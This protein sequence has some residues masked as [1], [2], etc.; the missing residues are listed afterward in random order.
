M[1]AAAF[2][3]F[4]L[5]GQV[6]VDELALA[7]YREGSLEVRYV[8]A[9]AA[10]IEQVAAGI[11][12]ARGRL[13]TRRASEIAGALG[14]VGAR[15]VDPTDPMRSEALELLPVTSG[16][17]PK[18]ASA[19]LDGMAADWTE[20]PLLRLLT[21]ELGGARAL[22]GFVAG[23]PD[24]ASLPGDREPASDLR[25]GTMAVG[26][27][28]CVQIVAG[29]VPGVGVTALIRSLL[30]KGPTLLKPG[31]GDVVLPVL[32]AR[33]LR[34]ADPELADALA[35]V[36][37]P[38]G[39]G[40]LEEAALA[41]ADVVT[42]YGSD[43]TVRALRARTPVTA[44]FVSYHHRVSV[45]VVGRDALASPATL[46]RTAAEVAEAVAFFDQRGC[47]CPQTIFVE[48]PEDLASTFAA[49]VADELDRLEEEL[50]SGALDAAE[51]SSLHQFRGAVEMMAAAGDLEVRHGG[52]SP[53]TV[54]LESGE[55][56]VGACPGRTVRLRVVGD[57]LEVPGLLTPI[58]LHLQTVGVAGGVDAVEA[59]AAELGMLGACRVVPF[60]AVPFPPPW[61]HH[62]GRGPLRDLVRWV[63][64]ERE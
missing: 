24:G 28:L 13:S 16:L 27:R 41:A 50:P 45:G 32:F 52:A 47:V 40:E 17:S 62:D 51:A 8:D 14:R 18:M 33:A 35:V 20:A 49:A 38:G 55:R 57:V 63:D 46:E 61:W 58:S 39:R 59:L 36:Y 30:L 21:A 48:G 9:S 10:W 34:E 23:T 26:P 2:D 64:L 6:T 12:A 3:A 7:G 19:V 15:F 1:S 56:M 54:V 25:A 43:E 11:G 5:P 42:A 29:S 22:D 4:A 60:R 31:R 37:W 44:R 53:W